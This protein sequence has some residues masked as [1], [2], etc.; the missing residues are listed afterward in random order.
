REKAVRREG[1]AA[2]PDGVAHVGRGLIQADAWDDVVLCRGRVVE[3]QYGYVRADDRRRH[4]VGAGVHIRDGE[5]TVAEAANSIGAT[6]RGEA[7]VT[8][9]QGDAAVR[10]EAAAADRGSAAHRASA[11]GQAD[12]WV[13]GITRRSRV[14]VVVRRRHGVGAN[15]R[16]W[17]GQ[18]TI[19]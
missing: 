18:H 6:V 9:G 2:H 12:A 4:D 3:A 14:R 5:R 1:A 19:A 15:A 8:D 13:D 17:D 10:R 16:R 11:R 7:V